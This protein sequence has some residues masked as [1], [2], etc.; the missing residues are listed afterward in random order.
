MRV[1]PIPANGTRTVQITIDQLLTVS[2]DDYALRLPMSFSSSI[3][4]FA[5]SV[6][7]SQK[8]TATRGLPNVQSNGKN[9]TFSA[10]NYVAKDWLAF[11]IPRK[12][13]D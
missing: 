5:L 6:R 7:S 9:L 12:I 13:S 10:K 8:V 4:N 2:G 1:Y 3:Q 11:S